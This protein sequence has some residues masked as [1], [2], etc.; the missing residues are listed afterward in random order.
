MWN[1]H[2]K[3]RVSKRQVSKTLNISERCLYSY[4]KI[5]IGIFD[6]EQ[7][8]PQSANSV[9]TRV[10]LTDYQKWVIQGLVLGV[11]SGLLIKSELVELWCD[12]YL[13]KDEVAAQLT[14]EKYNQFITKE[15]EQNESYAIVK[16]A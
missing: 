12:E 2:L 10:G 13:I 9:V 8:Y 1:F 16:A 4:L 3:P 14:K 6:F 11:Q 15:T 7:D 5:A